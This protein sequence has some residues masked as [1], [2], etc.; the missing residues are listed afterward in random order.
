MTAKGKEALSDVDA[1]ANEIIRF[2][3]VGTGLHNF[4]RYEDDRIGNLGMAYSVWLLN[5]FGSK[6]HP[7]RFY[8]EHY[9]KVVNISEGFNSYAARV[10]DRLFYWLGIVDVRLNREGPPPFEE[11]YKKT[12]LLSMIFSFKSN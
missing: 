1:A 12:D 9:Q 6:W 8:Q 11:E 10:F 2:S 7:G 4:D 5:K 3:H